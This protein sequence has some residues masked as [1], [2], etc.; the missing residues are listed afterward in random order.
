MINGTVIGIVLDNRDPDGMHRV[1]VEFPVDL[2]GLRSSWCRLMSPMAGV[3]RG[4]VILP[5]IG[6]EVLLAFAYRSM[7]P[8]VLGALYNGAEDRPEP[9]R[10]DDG[11]DNRRV[12]WSR[13]GHMVDF[14][15]SPGAEKVGLAGTAG[16]RLDVESGPVHMV[17]DDAGKTVTV[18][19][20]GSAFLDAARHFSIKCKT[21]KLEADQVMIGAAQ[22]VVVGAR[23]SQSITSGG[24]VRVSSPD[25]QVK[26]GAGPAP[27]A[28]EA[29]AEALHPPK[30]TAA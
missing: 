28:A 20:E 16:Q 12:F 25:T 11:Q 22:K 26:T 23:Q 3:G 30:R 8:Y 29:A 27:I 15:D 1:L 2:E 19:S 10:N 24:V 5:D 18:R 7:S 13:S 14:D 6:T 17:F 21:F 9:Y 4:L